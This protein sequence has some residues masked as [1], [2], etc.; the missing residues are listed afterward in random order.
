MVDWGELIRGLFTREAAFAVSVAILFAGLVLTYVVWRWVRSLL[1]NAGIGDAVEGTPFERTA[2]GFGTSTIGML[3]FLS[4]VAFYIGTVIIALNIAQL[5]NPNVFWSHFTGYL[6]R[7]FIA[8]V[9][10][11]VGMVLG[12][13]G[14]LYVSERLRSIK[15]PEAE[16]IPEIVRYSIFYT[17]ALLALAQLGVATAALLVLLAAYTFGLV[18]LAGL[19]FKDLLAAS[20]AGVYLL[21]T[22]PYTIGDEVRIDDKRGIVQEIDMFVTRI[23]ADGEEYIVPNQEVF[24]SGVVRVRN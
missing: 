20:A 11:I 10:I 15:V 19:A 23:E 3:S 7:L 6:P 21:L 24:R 22:E 13:K 8:A 4:A 18:L 9:A 1:V 2:R 16:I 14:R 17:A 12:D 5:L